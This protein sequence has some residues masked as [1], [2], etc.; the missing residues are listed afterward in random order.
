LDLQLAP[1]G[2]A[3]V[4]HWG[5]KASPGSTRDLGKISLIPAA[6][7]NGVVLLDEFP[8][9]AEAVNVTLDPVGTSGMRPSKRERL[10]KIERRVVHPD[11]QGGFEISPLATGS[12]AVEAASGDEWTSSR[13]S[14]LVMKP[15]QTL[16]LKPPLRLLEQAF[17]ELTVDP[18]LDPLDQQW[19]I[20][21]GRN[22][23]DV[24]YSVPVK[25]GKADAS[26]VWVVGGLTAG[27]HSIT[28]ETSTGDRVWQKNVRLDGG[29]NVVAVEVSFVAIRGWLHAGDQPLSGTL[30]FTRLDGTKVSIKAG[31]KGRFKGILPT[32]GEWRVKAVLDAGG[33]ERPLGTVDVERPS[34]GGAAEVDLALPDTLISGRVVR[35]DLNDGV[36]GAG[37]ALYSKGGD[38]VS[39]SR[40]GVDGEFHFLGIDPGRLLLRAWA[41]NLESRTVAVELEKDGK[42]K[43]IELRLESGTELTARVAIGGRPAVGAEVWVKDPSTGFSSYGSLSDP[44][45]VLTFR[46]PPGT[47]KLVWIGKLEGMPITIGTI[48]VG[49]DKTQA[50][51]L[52]L[53]PIGGHLVSPVPNRGEGADA[54]FSRDGSPFVYVTSLF[55]AFPSDGSPPTGLDTAN[56]QFSFDLAPGDYLVCPGPKKTDDC[57]EGYL[58]PNGW[59]DLEPTHTKKSS[60]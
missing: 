12:F 10:L 52:A 48:S 21:V 57:A 20:K 58:A 49:E 60:Q 25:N 17:V 11:Q 33:S 51:S 1:A 9:S 44:T 22:L 53:S 36:Q 16:T 18:P 23:P 43:D 42:E 15:G 59:L 31:T 39:S 4:T 41:K 5:V 29:R 34:R 19:R 30:E 50:V 28:V 3:P 55:G 47:S 37:I 8:G 32:P 7:I 56:G 26:G 40:S 35:G 6:T 38:R 45:G 14:P 13:R 27:S 24:I 54:Y 2:Y 46:V